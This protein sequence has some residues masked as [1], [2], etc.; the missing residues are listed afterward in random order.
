MMGSEIAI[1]I[2]PEIALLII[3]VSR[4]ETVIGDI[5]NYTVAWIISAHSKP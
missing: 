1:A 4:E 5:H 2:S 3:S